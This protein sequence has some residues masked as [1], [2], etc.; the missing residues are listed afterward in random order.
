MRII[1]FL[2]EE[3]SAREMLR[4]L[5]PRVLPPDVRPM[6]ITFQ[7]KQDLEKNLV[8]K[9]RHWRLPESVFVVM[10]DQDAGDCRAIKRKLLDLCRKTGKERVLVRIA[11]RALESF[12]LGDLKAVEKGLGVKRVA[13][14]QRRSKF[15]SPDALGD[16]H[17]E[18]CR[19]TTDKYQ[20]IA[21]SRN[22]APHLALE[23]NTSRSFNALLAGIQNLCD[24]NG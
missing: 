21:G 6:Y 15:R 13:A 20:K 24:G 4:G 8:R 10:R 12:Y 7:G 18:L 17:R 2:L 22:I 9:M 19:L 5:L 1:V 3:S 23:G 14:Q 16:P 11:C